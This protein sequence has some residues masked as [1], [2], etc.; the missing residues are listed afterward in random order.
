MP[1]TDRIND[2]WRVTMAA[3]TVGGQVQECNFNL[4]ITAQ[5]TQDTRNQVLN[6]INT[7]FSTNVNPFMPQSAHYKGC[8]MSHVRTAFP[9]APQLAAVD[10][11]GS[12]DVNSLPTALR[13]LIRLRTELVG[14]AYRGRLFAFTPGSS[15]LDANGKPT[16][17]VGAAWVQLLSPYMTGY[18]T[19]GTT[20]QLVIYHRPKPS[21]P[22]IEPTVVNS[23]TN[24]GLYG[25]QH[26]SGSFGR[27]NIAPW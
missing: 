25:T 19:F 20:W 11:Q 26:R 18:V 9:Y 17:A 14:T 5:G 16:A 22:F 2:V 24:S 15:V 8:K 7:D 23:V 6:K 10:Q 3:T 27:P 13:P 21:A 4:M 1:Y 12:G